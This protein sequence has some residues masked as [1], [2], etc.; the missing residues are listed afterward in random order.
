VQMR[1]DVQAGLTGCSVGRLDDG[2]ALRASIVDGHPIFTCLP[3]VMFVAHAESHM[4]LAAHYGSARAGLFVWMVHEAASIPAAFLLLH[5][6]WHAFRVG[7]VG[8]MMYELV[9]A[10]LHMTTAG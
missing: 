3:C 1:D 6:R 7:C 9:Y 5:L 2:A 8:I 4:L 10:L